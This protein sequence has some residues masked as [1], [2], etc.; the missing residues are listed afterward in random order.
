MSETP[1][2]GS[3]SIARRA[4]LAGAVLTASALMHWL[5]LAW[6]DDGL[7]LP[8]AARSRSAE[9][10]EVALIAQSVPPPDV[11][12]VTVAP[13]PRPI[14]RAAPKP[15]AR[16]D[17]ITVPDASAVPAVTPGDGGATADDPGIDP[18]RLPGEGGGIPAG[19]VAA[20]PDDASGPVLE[21]LAGKIDE[22]AP[23]EAIN[24]GDALR[25]GAPL[26]LPPTG[27]WRFKVHY[28][29][30]TDGHQ[31]ASLDYSIA[32]DGRK[33]LLRSEGRAEGLTALLYSGVLSQSST[34]RLTDNGLEPERYAEQRGKRAERWAAVDRSASQVSFSGNPPVAWVT[35]AQDRLSVLVQIGLLARAAPGRFVAGSV[36]EIPELTLRDI[37]NAR[38][39]SHGQQILETP[40]GPIHALHLERIAPRRQGDPRID[41]WLGYD[42]GMLPVRI[43]LTDSGGR[44]LDQLSLP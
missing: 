28:G 39:A 26:P 27:H 2:Q 40:V 36:I 1:E 15:V 41:V 42:R 13:R 23:R 21:K 24:A 17:A 10:V 32:H 3:S 31:V 34:G 37:E 35:G 14:A 43:R 29:D 20:R 38:Y 8:G 44:V 4:L 30:Y 22:A 12:A 16:P 11:P 9:A 5:V 6:L 18:D 7:D 19:P 33:Y 25:Y